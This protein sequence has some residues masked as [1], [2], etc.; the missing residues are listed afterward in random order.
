MRRVTQK[1]KGPA[2]LLNDLNQQLVNEFNWAI[3]SPLELVVRR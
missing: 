3:E 2:T 1:V